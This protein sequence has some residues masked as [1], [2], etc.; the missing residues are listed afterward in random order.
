M[1]RKTL[2]IYLAKP[3]V[4]AF[5]DVLSDRA[6]DR[7]GDIRTQTVDAPEF[8]EGARLFVFA[9]AAFTPSWLTE[10]GRHF[11]VNANVITSSASAVLAFWVGQRLFVSTFASGWMSINEDNIEGDFGLRVALNDLND[12]KLRR[13]ERANLGDAMRGVSLSPFQRNFESF[14]MDDA[15]DRKICE[16]IWRVRLV[17]P[18]STG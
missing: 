10:L 3:D 15:L 2:T 11:D 7:L 4:Q 12:D 9:S 13:L 16:A 8:A 5:E 1:A 18:A 6:R 14:G 17:G